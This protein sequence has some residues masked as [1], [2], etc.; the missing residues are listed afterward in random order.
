MTDNTPVRALSDTTAEQ[1]AA[2]RVRHAQKLTALMV[3]REDLRGVHALADF[4]DDFRPTQR[5]FNGTAVSQHLHQSFDSFGTGTAI[6]HRVQ[7]EFK[8]TGIAPATILIG[9]FGQNDLVDKPGQLRTSRRS[10]R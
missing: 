6:A 8:V 7:I 3:E 9:L 1:R 4:V 10:P 5:R 2:L